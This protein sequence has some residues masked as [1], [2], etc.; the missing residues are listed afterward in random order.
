MKPYLILFPFHDKNAYIE[1]TRKMLSKN[2]EVISWEQLNKNPLLFFRLKGIHLNWIENT[3]T[4]LQKIQLLFMKLC[5]K[6][7]VWVF[8]NRMPHECKD[9]RKSKK[10]F[11]FMARISSHILI[12]SRESRILA[13]RLLLPK[14]QTPITYIE[15]VNYIGCYRKQNGTQLREKLKIDKNCFLFLFTGSICPYK[16]IEFMIRAFKKAALPNAVLLIA[17]RAQDESYAEHLS[18]MIGND[19]SILFENGYIPD[20]RMYAYLNAANVM[21]LPHSKASTL[22]SGM[23]IMAFSYALPVI[24]TD[25]AMAADFPSDVLYQ[26][27]YH[28]PAEK[29]SNLT[30]AII[31]AYSAGVEKNHQMGLTAQKLMK[32]QYSVPAISEKLASIYQ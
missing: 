26:Y 9:R 22:N 30:D 28:S 5:K 24:T 23:M 1:N 7:I 32:T 13:E 29:L 12:H 25:I 20:N 10:N 19:P 31:T 6:K 21:I 11:I 16:N 15:H 18:A 14:Q 2:Y 8:H 3:I 4:P 27:T 17:G